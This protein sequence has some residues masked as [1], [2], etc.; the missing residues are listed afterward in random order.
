MGVGWG[1]KALYLNALIDL[2]G[3]A[4]KL[5]PVHF[6]A[7][8]L[9]QSFLETR[10]LSGTAWYCDDDFV[11]FFFDLIAYQNHPWEISQGFHKP[12]QSFLSYTKATNQI[13]GSHPGDTTPDL[14]VDPL[15][16]GLV[17]PL[18]YLNEPEGIHHPVVPE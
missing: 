6:F 11:L 14:F 2:P 13:L 15:C 16:C 4:C 10:F 17:E 9:F 5:T 12:L 1:K 3:K 18:P 7:Y 8:E